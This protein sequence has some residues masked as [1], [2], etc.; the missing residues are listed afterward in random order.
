MRLA[1]IQSFSS[2]QNYIIEWKTIRDPSEFW[3][4]LQVFYHNISLQQTID[5]WKKIAQNPADSR[6]LG[7]GSRCHLL[8]ANR[9]TT[10]GG[11]GGVGADH[12][13]GQS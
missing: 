6:A 3:G 10:A 7:S 11:A 9:A 13:I 5:S 8:C 2:S 1:P 4:K 12:V